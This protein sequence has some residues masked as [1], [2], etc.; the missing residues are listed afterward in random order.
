MKHAL[1]KYRDQE[2]KIFLES[3]NDKGSKNQPDTE[4][5]D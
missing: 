4:M 1:N 5:Q 2:N 3:V